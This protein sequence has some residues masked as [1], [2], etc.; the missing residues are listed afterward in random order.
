MYKKYIIVVILVILITYNIIKSRKSR[1]NLINYKKEIPKNIF[2]SS[3]YPLGTLSKDLVNKIDNIKKKNNDFNILYYDQDNSKLFIKKEYPELYDKYVNINKYNEQNYLWKLLIIYKFGGT[4]LNIDHDL[5]I[6]LSNIITNEEFIAAPSIG[7]HILSAYPKHPFIKKMIESFFDENIN[8]VNIIQ[9]GINNFFNNEISD[10]IPIGKYMLEN[11]KLNIYTNFSDN[12]IID[13]NNNIIIKLGEDTDIY[14][15]ITYEIPKYIYMTSPFKEEDLP[16]IIENQLNKI[17]IMNPGYQIFYY[18]DENC[19]NFIKENFKE[20]L[21]DY[22]I[23]I[24]SAYKA[25]LWRYLILYKF[26]GIYM[27]IGHLP[28]KPFSEIIDIND[29]FI[30][31]RDFMNQGIHN[32]FICVYPKH[33]LI[34]M[35]ID[36]TIDNIRKQEYGINW[37][38]ITGP[39]TFARAFNR[40]NSKPELQLI[41]EGKLLINNNMYKF[42]YL[43]AN[44][45][46][47]QETHIVDLNNKKI[48][49]TKFKDYY[50]IMYSNLNKPRYSV[51]WKN[52]KVFINSNK[53]IPKSIYITDNNLEYINDLKLNNIEYSIK[54]YDENDRIEFIKSNNYIDIYNKIK[55]K[56]DRIDFWK[57]LIL[58][59]YGGIY[60]STN[61]ISIIKFKELIELNDEFI[62]YLDKDNQ[63]IDNFICVYPKHKFIKE[64]LNNILNKYTYNLSFDNNIIF[65]RLLNKYDTENIIIG[66]YGYSDYVFNFFTVDQNN[67][68]IDE[69]DNK[70]IE[71]LE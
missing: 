53:I 52:K 16:S 42:F 47:I 71:I 39:C 19:R 44:V 15:N 29:E 2:L 3:I 51:L 20:Y 62:S 34:K 45:L 21:Y 49:K 38:D 1:I 66:K 48:I 41:P 11:Y 36:I 59:K 10:I 60:I 68:I 37:L 22:D 67:N 43:D 46:K 40:L 31:V 63:I 65:N 6:P 57:Y 5:I 70:I 24:P 14:N 9:N 56:K 55:I 7:I 12:Y 8:E 69:F 61:L 30:S 4:Y 35:T 64:L 32:A 13:I 58:Y 50:N 33:P 27:D 26:G 25:D 23:L 17:K 54:Y 28:L 18:N